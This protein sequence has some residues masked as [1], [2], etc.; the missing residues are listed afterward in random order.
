MTSTLVVPGNS[1]VWYFDNTSADDATQRIDGLTAVTLPGVTVNTGGVEYQTPTGG[2]LTRTPYKSMIDHGTGS[3]TYVW[4][5]S[6]DVQA[7][8]R[9][10]TFDN[11]QHTLTY[12]S[13]ARVG[14]N[15][16][17]TNFTVLMTTITD[18]ADLGDAHLVESEFEVVPQLEPMMVALPDAVTVS[19]AGT[20]TVETSV[21]FNL[22]RY[23]F[24]PQ[25][26][27]A[28]YT[29]STASASIA[30]VNTPTVAAP[31]LTI[32]AVGMGTTTVSVQA[33]SGNGRTSTEQ[34]INATVVA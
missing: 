10:A 24:N 7:Q 28:S 23:F 13:P 29:V 25:D 32:T 18:T 22:S 14:M 33:V 11:A 16:S 9:A 5:P 8:M 4:N 26:P 30:S 19:V 6:S 31:E 17:T 3:L 12:R 20:S 34:T 2:P 21:T 27:I 1:A 15:A